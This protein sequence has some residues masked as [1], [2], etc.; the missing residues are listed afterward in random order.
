[1]TK[2]EAIQQCTNDNAR[3][4]I[5]TSDEE[6]DFYF[7]LHNRDNK[8]G[9]WIGINDET[10]EGKWVTDNREELSWFSWGVTVS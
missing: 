3:L 4:P 2:S 7:Y 1:M 9:G 5:P 8:Y 10:K 6:N